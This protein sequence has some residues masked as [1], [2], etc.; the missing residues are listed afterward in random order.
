MM[1]RGQARYPL[2]LDLAGRRVLV[3]GGGAVAARR[4][5]SLLDAGADVH[6]VAPETAEAM[7]DHARFIDSR[8]RA[9]ELPNEVTP[10]ISAPS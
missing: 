8:C 5:R 3:V 9:P 10:C 6:V 1:R 4:V 2:H 7:P